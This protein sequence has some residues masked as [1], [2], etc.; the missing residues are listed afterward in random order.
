MKTK[1]LVLVSALSLMTAQSAFGSGFEKSIPWG[2]ETSGLAGIGSPYMQNSQALFFNP[3][4]LAGDKVGQDVSFNI[5]P[6]FATF[7]APITDSTKQETSKSNPVFPLS[8]IYGHTLNDKI[9]YGF[10]FYTAGGMANDYE[11]SK[12]GVN[13]VYHNKVKLAINELA[14][15]AGY[16]VM[17]NLKVGAT[18]RIGMV[19]GEFYQAGDAGLGG[20]FEGKYTDLSGSNYFGLK[21]GAQYKLSD[22]THLSFVYRSEMTYK[23]KGKYTLATSA[24]GPIADGVDVKVGTLLPAAW[25]LGA[26]HK[27]NDTWNL[28]GEYV[29]TEYS[30]VTNL[31]TEGGTSSPVELKWKDQHNVRLAA[32]YSGFALPVRVGYVW[33]SQVTHKDHALPSLIPPGPANTFTLGTGHSFGSFKVDGGFE[34]TMVSGQATGATVDNEVSEYAL[35]LGASYSF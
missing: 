30:K 12:T 7:K 23:A 19:N 29:F 34:Y 25:T 4:G 26:H 13:T 8:L 18:Y 32:A 10:G 11:V 20:L 35:H 31:S 33:T 14:L 24:G 16:K 17:D 28:Y 5:S 6:T 2:G 3:A 15:G 22:D 1:S 9:G 27:L 21:L